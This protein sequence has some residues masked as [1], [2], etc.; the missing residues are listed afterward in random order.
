MVPLDSSS[1]VE[2]QIVGWT[3]PVRFKFIGVK[4]FLL[5][6]RGPHL[7][8]SLEHVLVLNVGFGLLRVDC[9]KIPAINRFASRGVFRASV[10]GVNFRSE[11]LFALRDLNLVR[12]EARLASRYFSRDYRSSWPGLIELNQFL[13]VPDKVQR[14][15]KFI[16]S[17][18]SGECDVINGAFKGNSVA[19]YTR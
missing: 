18:R 13:S 12:M 16:S 14:L 9:F 10:R 5:L 11:K 4:A 17:R 6:E 8:N 1:C 15:S 19:F 2:S 3:E 7:V